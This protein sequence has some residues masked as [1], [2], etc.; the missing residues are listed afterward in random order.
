MAS[1]VTDRAPVVADEQSVVAEG[2]RIIVCISILPTGFEP[3]QSRSEFERFLQRLATSCEQDV[4]DN[5]LR[6][7]D[8]CLSR[9][10]YTRRRRLRWA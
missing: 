4:L 1:V 3:P 5:I 6:F 7:A 9:S 10:L 8:G 2:A